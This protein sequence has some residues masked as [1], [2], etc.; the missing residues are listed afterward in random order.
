M[1]VE[2]KKKYLPLFFDLEGEP[3]LVLGGGKVAYRKIILLLDAGAEVTVIA[4]E[5]NS[6]ITELADSGRIFLR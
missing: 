4:P 1:T 2:L 6:E 5:I 3:C